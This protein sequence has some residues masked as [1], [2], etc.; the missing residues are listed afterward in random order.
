MATKD[1]LKSAVDNFFS[2]TYDITNGTVIP[3]ISDVAFGKEGKE[4]EL[5]MLFK[6]VG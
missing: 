1:D 6:K 2:G 4:I 3:N 5:A